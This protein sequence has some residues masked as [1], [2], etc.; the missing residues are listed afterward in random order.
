M[1]RF[2][3]ALAPVLAITGCVQHDGGDHVNGAVT[4]AAG[5]PAADASTVNGGI[6]V[7]AGAAV[8]H[9]STVNGDITIGDRATAE[10]IEAVNGDITIG[11]GARVAG[12]ISTVNGD[13]TLRKG[14][15]VSGELANV[16]GDYSV[17]AAHVGGGIRTVGGDIGV[18]AGSRIDGGITV[19]DSEGF[20]ISFVKRV[21][22]ITIGPGA[23]VRGP[24]NFDREVKLYVSDRAQIGAVTGA[25]PVRFSGD[26]PPS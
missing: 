24:L 10:S 18:G 15:D 14:A 12:S 20:S 1:R 26:Q 19:E 8:K 4:V 23:V 9:V 16:N 13:V 25:T 6:D 3:L 2:L 11:E 5:R 17:L 22:V 21:P 7:A